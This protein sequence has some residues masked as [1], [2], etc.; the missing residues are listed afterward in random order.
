[1][2]I[3]LD[4]LVVTKENPRHTPASE[5]S[6]KA[7]VASLATHGLIQPLVV[8]PLEN[9]HDSQ[10][11]EVI[12]GT[13]R[14]AAV[15]ELGWV[16]VECVENDA[17]YG[18]SELGAAENMLREAMHPLDECAVISRLV[19][20]GESKDAVAGRFGQTERWVEQR[21]K[22]NSLAPK[23][24]KCFREGGLGMAAAQAYCLVDR[25]AQEHYF[26]EGK[27]DHQ[28]SAG[29][30][31]SAFSRQSYNSR[32]AMFRLEDYPQT[33]VRRDLF[34]EDVW[35][36]D[37]D[38]YNRLQKTAIVALKQKLMDEEGWGDVL[39]LWD[40]PDYTITGKYV[41][42]EGKI[43]KADRAKY[44]CIIVYSPGSGAAIVHKGYVARKDAKKIETGKTAAE[45]KAK[46]E[47]VEAKTADD[48]SLNQ[49]VIVA[50]YQTAGIE[51]AL[52]D[53]D[54]YLALVTL[55]GPFLSHDF[56][57]IPPWCGGRRHLIDYDPVNAMLTTA[58]DQLEV[59]DDESAAYRMPS[60]EALEKM[61]V[62]E[63]G[64]LLCNAALRSM[65]R[66]PMPSA[67][68]T[69]QLKAAEVDWMRMPEGF[70]KRYRLDQLHDLAKRMKVDVENLGKADTVKALTNAAKGMS[71]TRTLKIEAE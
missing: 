14:L 27:K 52:V 16:D 23:I 42:A 10:H 2:K 15:S 69:K 34:G 64:D 60:R 36:D 55:L 33:Q 65:I 58:G 41:E 40:G 68:A 8:R 29:A 20:D 38:A 5:A 30:I 57:Q 37:R 48:L 70:L 53:G 46:V 21:M 66:I 31:A 47:E 18:V 50:A 13:R 28:I 49:S 67:L 17:E 3:G 63:L 44:V 4:K 12:A 51:Q 11:W 43:L 71:L 32:N 25:K 39:I 9:G 22:L 35:L 61:K 59:Q 6:H 19:A 45:D 26:G 1:M 24:A 62:K 54:I 7:L 56:K